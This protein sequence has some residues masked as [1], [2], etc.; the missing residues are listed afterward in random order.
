L[1]KIRSRLWK[2]RRRYT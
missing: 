1:K 2:I